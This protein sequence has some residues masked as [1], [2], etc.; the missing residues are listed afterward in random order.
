[1]TIVFDRQGVVRDVIE[2]IM[3]ADEFD[4]KVRPRL[5]TKHLDRQ[6]QPSSRKRVKETTATIVVG[7]NGY[8]PASVRLRHG[9]PARLT[10]IRNT[11]Q[12]CGTEIVIPA[13]KVKR[14]LPLNVPVVVRFIPQRSGRYKFT[15]GMDMFRGALVVR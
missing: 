1:M 9:V 5:F 10:F 6:Q 12:T 11:E 13:Y 4:K 7:T 14:P 15:C 2:G 3:F 8:Q